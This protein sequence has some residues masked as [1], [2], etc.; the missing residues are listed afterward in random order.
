[1]TIV[2][3]SGDRRR[4]LPYLRLDESSLLAE[5]YNARPCA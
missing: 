5:D 1:M 4:A 3:S 2:K